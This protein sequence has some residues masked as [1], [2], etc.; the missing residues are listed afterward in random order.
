MCTAVKAET[1]QGKVYLGRTMDFSYPLAP[2]LYIVPK[3]YEWIPLL[4]TQKIRNRYAFMGIGQNISPIVFADGVNEMGTAGAVLYF[5]GYAQYDAVQASAPAIAALELLTLVLG[6]CASLAQVALLMQNTRLLGVKDAIS[7]SI[8]PLHW[9]F[10][11]QSGQCLVIEK[12]AAGLQLFDNPLG[13]LANSPDFGWQMTNL[14]NYFALSPYQSQEQVWSNLALAPFGQGAGAIGLPGDYT[15]PARFVRMAYMKTHTPIPADEEEAVH[16]CF[17][18]L[19]SVTIPKGVV[20]TERGSADYT[21]YSAFMDLTSQ[22]YFF[23]TY[24][25]SQ[26]TTV[27]L[28]DKLSS[29]SGMISL[30][31]LCRLSNF[32]CW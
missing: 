1:P 13:V 28:T 17:H 23:K 7:Q 22:T 26:I 21:Q 2:E 5:P 29:Q 6:Q 20:M 3:G 14:R 11:D 18:L 12:T 16:T 32:E 30:G 4:H 31:K 8:A 19:D 27:K 9:I 15:P 24:N 25:N 10:A